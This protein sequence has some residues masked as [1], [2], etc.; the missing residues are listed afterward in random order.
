MLPCALDDAL[1]LMIPVGVGA[2]SEEQAANAPNAAMVNTL[3]EWNHIISA[4][5]KEGG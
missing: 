2:L 4:F 1:A 5:S 3:R